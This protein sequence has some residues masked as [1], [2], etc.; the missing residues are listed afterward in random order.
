MFSFAR[1]RVKARRSALVLVLAA[2]LAAAV[3]VPSVFARAQAA[4]TNTAAPGIVAPPTVGDT[5]SMT[6]GLWTGSPTSFVYGWLRCPA[7]GG[8]AGGS[9]CTT[10]PG[11]T[12]RAYEVES[13]DVGNRLR[14]R[15]T[16]TNA[17]GSGNA[18]SSPTAVTV[19]PPD[20]N[21]TGCPPVQQAGPLDLDEIEPPA[22]LEIDQQSS[23][24]AVIT[25][26]TLRITLRFQVRACDGRKV[27]GALVY[28]T[29][30]PY[31][32]FVGPERPTGADGWATITLTRQRFF[33]ATPRQQNLIVFVR[34][35]KPGDDLLGGISNRRLV[36]FRVRL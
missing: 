16:A 15:E 9:D 32:Q 11:A 28:A 23:T 29:P 35:R 5:L 22:R 31:Q 33:P 36:S 3:L 18:T 27:R 14:V 20:Q 10:V 13:D 24:P 25:R 19:A 1:R 17:D 6:P 12:S 8:A 34:A 7:S 26:A 4:P 2:A 21:I 30:T